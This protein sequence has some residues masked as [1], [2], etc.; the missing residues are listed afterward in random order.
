MKEPQWMQENLQKNMK[1]T[2]KV[3]MTIYER[4]AWR[5]SERV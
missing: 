4:E 1:Y 3:R 5:E 2:I